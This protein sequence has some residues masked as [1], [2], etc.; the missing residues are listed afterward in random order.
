MRVRT[1]RS[2]TSSAPWRAISPSATAS[3][4]PPFAMSPRFA[5]WPRRDLSRHGVSKTG[6]RWRSPP[7]KF[8]T[9]LPPRA[10]EDS[11]RWGRGA[12]PARYS[13]QP[14]MGRPTTQ[15]SSPMSGAHQSKFSWS[16]RIPS[17]FRSS[18]CPTAFFP[19]GSWIG[20][21]ARRPT[22]LERRYSGFGVETGRS[23]D[24]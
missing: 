16:F 12:T 3:L 7:S 19:V 13:C 22:Y 20:A 15:R 4:N 18:G 24:A 9:G 21:A 17:P 2:S 6:G 1:P 10:S 8:A 14:S 11:I 23:L 5:A